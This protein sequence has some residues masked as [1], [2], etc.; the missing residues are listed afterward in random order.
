MSL[1]RDIRAFPVPKGSVALWWLGQNGFIF[2]SPEGTVAGVDLYLTDSCAPLGASIGVNTSRA[3]PVLITPEELDV[4][5]FAC[6]HNHQDHTDPETI[7]NLR[8]KDTFAFLGPHPSCDTFRRE[9]VESGRITP[10]WPQCELEF[11]DLQLR[12]TFALP[13]DTTDLCHMGF[14]L[15]FGDGPKIYITGD[16]DYTDLLHEAAS[17]KPDM[18]VTCINGGYNNLSFWEAAQLAS[19][20][21]PRVA[22]PCHYDMFPNNQCDPYMFEA[23]L[24]TQCPDVRYNRM[25][26]GRPLLFEKS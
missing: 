12:G 8:N 19:A 10:A 25:A 23:A 20:V 6:T 2:K 22:T 21:K 26:H 5:L 18:L 9:G 13:T 7:R 1:M 11:R 16:T 15:Q 4:D 17:H 24:K 14:I 3:V